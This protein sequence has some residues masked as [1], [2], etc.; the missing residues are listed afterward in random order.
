[1]GH[2]TRLLG[3]LLTL[4]S[5]APCFHCKAFKPTF[6]S[7]LVLLK[8][9]MENIAIEQI[10]AQSYKDKNSN[11]RSWQVSLIQRGEEGATTIWA[12]LCRGRDFLSTI[13]TRFRIHLTLPSEFRSEMRN[14]CKSGVLECKNVLIRY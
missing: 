13:P 11:H 1:M 3:Y 10:A 6:V 8:C 4:S 14:L 12:R 5:P 9:W 2:P 7:L